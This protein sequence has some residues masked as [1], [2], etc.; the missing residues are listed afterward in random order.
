MFD[1]LLE[2]ASQRRQAP[3]NLKAPDLTTDV[4]PPALR[5]ALPEQLG[6][7]LETGKGPLEVLVI[8]GL[9]RPTDN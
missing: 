6:L 3:V 1:I 8:D 4:A 2:Y 9:E 5:D 7:R